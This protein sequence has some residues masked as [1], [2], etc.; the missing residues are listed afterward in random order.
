MVTAGLALIFLLAIG[1]R[2]AP[3]VFSP[4]GVGIDHWYWKTYV[5]TYRRERQSAGGKAETFIA[6]LRRVGIEPFKAAA[7]A[8]RFTEKEVA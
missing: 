1:L 4:R 3:V 7:N 8:A 6:T 5:E 2:V